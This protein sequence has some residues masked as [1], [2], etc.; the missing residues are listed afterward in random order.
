[1]AQHGQLA[2]AVHDRR[3]VDA[4]FPGLARSQ[5]H[6][7]GRTLLQYTS[8][9]VELEQRAAPVALP[10]VPK[11]DRA[12]ARLDPA[13]AFAVPVLFGIL[14][15]DVAVLVRVEERAAVE[16]DQVGFYRHA[17]ACIRAAAV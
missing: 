3:H 4:Q 1:A 16:D 5:M 14:R 8:L 17:A 9:P 10:V 2:L 12:R 11:G 7:E 15:V 13:A 6:V